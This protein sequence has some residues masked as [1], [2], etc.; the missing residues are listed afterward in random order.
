M[1]S[2]VAEH[3]LAE[4][5]LREG[6]ARYRLLVDHSPDAIFVVCEE[7]IVFA[8][9]T[10]LKLLGA[11]GP[12]QVIGRNPSVF[13]HPDERAE[14]AYR[15]REVA[16]GKQPPA[17][18][19]RLLRLDGSAVEVEARLISF[20]Y[21]GKPALQ[22][23]A[24]DKTERKTAADKLNAQENQYRLLFEDNPTPM[25]VYDAQTFS[26]L[27][28][29]QAAIAGYG[30]SRG[31]FLSRTLHAL[32]LSEDAAS[33]V[34]STGEC[35]HV[36]KDG[37]IIIAA[38]YSSPTIF[39]QKQARMGLAVDITERVEAEHRVRESEENLALAQQVAG[40]G[41][42]EYP[43]TADGEIDEE[44]LIW[45]QEA[46]RLFGLSPEIP[47]ST[48]TFFEAVNPDDRGLVAER[49]TTFKEGIG[50]YKVDFRI[51]RPDGTERIV[52]CVA[53]RVFDTY[54]GKPIK[55]VGTALDI[56][57]LR[58][59]E[60]QLREAEEKY[61]SI[62]D[63]SQEGI[64]QNTPDGL[65]LSANPA[66]A[67]MF[68]FA[69]PEEMIRDHN[70]LKPQS[71]SN[72]AERQEFKRLIEE[73]GFVNNF[74]YEV[75]RK[76][77]SAIWVSENVL[78]VRDAVGEALHYEG[79]V[80]DITERK[81][82]EQELLRSEERFRSFTK[83]TWEIVWQTDPA[84]QV[85]EDLPSWRAYTGQTTEE[86]LG[87]GWINCVHPDDRDRTLRHW[88]ECR[89]NK[90]VCENEYRMRGA[91]GIYRLFSARGVPVFDA[92]GAVREWIGAN[93][94]ITERKQAE[95]VLA[96]SE[97]RFRFL[98]DLSDATRFLSQPKEIMRAAA[99]LLGTHLHVSRCAYAEV[100]KDGDHLHVPGDYTDGCASVVG[101]FRLSDFGESTHSKMAAGRTLVLHDV[102]AELAPH[103]GAE[104][105][106]AIEIKAMISCPLI[107]NGDLVAMMAVHH[108]V[109][110]QWTNAEVALVQEVVE[111]CWSIIE[112][113]R[114]ELVLRESEEHLRLVIA[115][116]NDGIW[117]HDYVNDILTWS[118]RM[119][120][121]FGLDRRTF[122]PS[123]DAFTTLLHPDDRLPFQNAVR[124]QMASGGRYEA[125]TRIL[126]GDGSFGNFLG[127]GR[128]VLDVLGKPIRIVGSLADL[129]GLLRAEQK[130]VEQ[131]NLL[132]LAHD[133]IMVRDMDDRVEFWNHGAEVLYGW[134]SA[135]TRGRL[136]GDFLHDEE[137]LTVSVA[138][139]T[140]LET[141]AWSG[142]CRHLTKQG[143][144]V[145]VR[146][147][148]T[149][150]RDERG[151]PKSKL[152]INTDIT[153]QKK[154]EE[155]F[156]RAQRLES[157]G[158]LASGV[159][160]DLNN[161]LVPIMMAAPV[162]RGEIDPAQRERFL[163]IVET[164]A[165]RGADIIKQVLT[166]ARGAD[167][168]RILLQPIFLLEEVSKIAGQTFPK[169]IALRTSYEENIRLLE[170]D[171]TQLHQLLLN[172]C[173]NARDAMPKRRRVM[174]WRREFRRRPALREQEP[175]CD[176]RAACA[177]PGHGQRQRHPERGHR[178]KSSTRSLPPRASGTG[179]ASDFPL[180]R[181]SSRATAALCMSPANR[182]APASR[183][184][185]RPKRRSTLPFPS[186][187]T[188]RC[189][190][191]LAKRFCWSTTN[192]VSGRSLRLSWRATATMSSSPKT[193]PPRSPFLPGRWDASLSS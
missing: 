18:Q 74:E 141:G 129:T 85:L 20:L 12:E 170:A 35:R 178:T 56:T 130:L 169:S 1:Q 39:D 180:S 182:D 4:Q 192:R 189:L 113:A 73:K 132:N 158:T 116:S 188:R 153:E 148:W 33:L 75:K 76:D 98:N 109:P 143:E 136:V 134:N 193:A 149:L 135:E 186:P 123:V 125:H 68:G 47:I 111:R 2:E 108:R 3:Q 185:F 187:R 183:F 82:S 10:T 138:R 86:I 167:G 96:E 162:L 164:S 55:V 84:G 29:N 144:T 155:Q 15:S 191:V 79:S 41:S 156:L 22:V 31:E 37:T 43:I 94:D 34:G 161:I 114:A 91:D 115:A 13:V 157:I 176:R 93:K 122:V 119:Y 92:H 6:E 30:Y 90:T 104:A 21:E 168:D 69:S 71:Y 5:A 160:H 174:P 9:P 126:R 101:D 110:R 179:L 184:F 46:Y 102:E 58:A 53:E 107:K 172:L 36:K 19:R 140:L 78:V 8:N 120:E 62:F 45:S 23:I 32:Y 63:N 57:E 139:R 145:I 64:F 103:E 137:P 50:S 128:V 99:R 67:R 11:D 100:E 25:W 72:P 151:Q 127:R 44:N 159:A 54:S 49:F 48:K 112:R 166:F 95:E 175:R 65:I 27:A 88:A 163:D 154:I 59:V 121:M 181:G 106:G 150:V 77:G 83:A 42:W 173:I 26:I 142:E 51:N 60:K 147:R 61:R 52:H 16:E 105:F 17:T 38:V 40:V 118:D 80:R 28:V 66:L 152:V 97:R 177:V 146:S 133:A 124:E 117:E 24:Q 165:Q 81:H 87:A 89:E 171:S 131:A 7:K 14:V 70:S 190:A